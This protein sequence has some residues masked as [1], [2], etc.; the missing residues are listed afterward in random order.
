[1]ENN[2]VLGLGTGST[3]RYFIE[4]LARYVKKENFKI[5][6]VPSSYDTEFYARSLGLDV[7]N[8]LQ[9]ID[10]TIDGA[11]LVDK[12]LNLIKGGGGALLREKLLAKYS[13]EVIIIVD[14]S[15]LCEKLY[16]KLPVEVVPFSLNYVLKV[17]N[18]YGKPVIRYSK[19][20]YGPE[21]T[22][23]YNFIVDIHLHSSIDN[24]KLLEREI[25]QITGVVESGL[26]PNELI[27]KVI[28]GTT[29]SIKIL[30]KK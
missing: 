25:K 10:I 28:I 11:D 3:V 21:I 24:P 6:C 12:E 14:E 17:L 23:N 30:E 2:I 9:E 15:K 26:F 5:K 27:S 7:D 29:S 18:K 13:N 4:E 20:K 19:T 1:M 22:D 8:V 16:G